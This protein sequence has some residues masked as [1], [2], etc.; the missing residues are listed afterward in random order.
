MASRSGFRVLRLV[1][2]LLGGGCFVTPHI[3][4]LR[5]SQRSTSDVTRAA[6]TVEVPG[7]LKN[8]VKM[9]M[10]DVPYMLMSFTSKKQGKGV[11]ITKAK[12]KNLLTGAII[13]KTLNSGSKFPE[14]ETA[15]EVGT[16]TYRDES[17][18][19]F[20]VMDME[21]FEDKSVP[22]DVMGEMQD[23]ISEGQ[24]VEWELW[25]GKI[26]NMQFPDDIIMEVATV[27]QS[28]DNGRDQIV[29]LSNGVSRQA[30]AYIEV[31][32]KVRID[33]K[34]FQITKRV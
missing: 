8:G 28:K 31:G 23:W 14:M 22:G 25:E 12:L 27:K 2:L 30:P 21:T 1:A 24:Q 17:D 3:G 33:K 10:D 13:E 6:G 4:L 7:G 9:V 16:F 11:A 20:H 19:S 18:N 34:N 29:T 5:A 32:D 26:V 15:W